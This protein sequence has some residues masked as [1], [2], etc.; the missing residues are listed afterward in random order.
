MAQLASLLQSVMNN[1]QLEANYSKYAMSF[2][3]QGTK[4]TYLT[5]RK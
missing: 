5:G 4:E 1:S 2:V 3:S